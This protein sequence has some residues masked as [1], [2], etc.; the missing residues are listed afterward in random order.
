MGFRFSKRL[1]IEDVGNEYVEA[2]FSDIPDTVIVHRVRATGDVA[3]DADAAL[4]TTGGTD[5]AVQFRTGAGVTIGLGG[6]ATA[7]V[8]LNYALS[9][10]DPSLTLD[11]PEPGIQITIPRGNSLYAAVRFDLENGG[12]PNGTIV[13]VV[14][15]EV[16]E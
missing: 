9:P 1:V 5:I 4:G 10:A 14:E 2:A 7:G 13:V 15:F 6:P 11:S 16:G 12:V 3:Q 8:P